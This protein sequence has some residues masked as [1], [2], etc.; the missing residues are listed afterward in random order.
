MIHRLLDIGDAVNW[1]D[2]LTRGLVSWWA[3]VPGS[4]RGNQW[5]DLCNRNH[6][7][8]T[9]GPTWQGPQGRVGGNGSLRLVS[10]GD[11]ANDFVR[12]NN[13][14]ASSPLNFTTALTL[15]VWVKTTDFDGPGSHAAI[16]SRWSGAA[17]YIFWAHGTDIKYG[18]D[19]TSGALVWSGGATQ[20]Q[21]GA[22]H[23]LALTH[24]SGVGTIFADGVSV[25][26][27]SVSQ[28][29]SL[30]GTNYDFLI[31][32]YAGAG[33]P[34]ITNGSYDGLI[35]DVGAWSR[36][37]SASEILAVYNDS[38]LG[39]PRMLN[40]QRRRI[41]TMGTGGGAYSVDA[42]AG[43]LVLSGSAAS[44]FHNKSLSA[45][46]GSFVLT[47]S[48]AS[49]LFG[50]S[51]SAGVGNLE[52]VGSD[53][54]IL[55]NSVID[56]QPGL[57]QLN[58]SSATITHEY[59]LS[60][61]VGVLQLSGSDAT[62]V[63]EYHLAADAGSLVLTGSDASIF[64]N[65]LLSVDAGTAQLSGSSAT[66]SVGY[67]LSADAGS[68]VLTG[69]DAT[70]DYNAAGNYNVSALAGSLIL[71]GSNASVLHN[72][73]LSADSDNLNLIG[74][75]ANILYNRF[76]STDAGSINTIGSSA[77]I[78]HGKL[79]SA[80]SGNVQLSGGAASILA[81]KLLN[82]S[83]GNLQF[84]GSSANISYGKLLLA[85]AGLVAL[86]GS[87]ANIT[88][89]RII[90]A[91]RG[92]IVFNGAS[93]TISSSGQNAYAE[94]V[95]STQ[96]AFLEGFW[97]L[98]ES[99]GATTAVDSSSNGNDSVSLLGNTFGI[100]TNLGAGSNTGSDFPG[101]SG[102]FIQLENNSSGGPL[103]LAEWTVTAW[104]K[105]DS[106]FGDTTT[107]GTGGIVAIPIVSK[108]RSE[109]DTP[110]LN[111]NYFLGLTAAGKLCG[112]F[113]STS[114]TNHPIT[115]GT[116]I[117]TDRWYFGALT[118]DGA[119]LKLYL[120]GSSDASPIATTDT[121]DSNTAQPACIGSAMNSSA[122]ANGGF[123]GIIDEVAIWGTAL[124]GSEINSLWEQGR[125]TVPILADIDSIST[126]SINIS[127]QRGLE[128]IES[129]IL[130]TI[131]NKVF[132]L[133]STRNK[134]FNVKK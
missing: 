54:T 16:I 129:F 29:S 9:N 84:S 77:S 111:L 127:V 63:H 24:A 51:L 73:F 50:Y 81:A 69:S 83:A 18:T 110:G 5:R 65:S 68:I 102:G 10:T 126:V 37:L 117:V 71:T 101:N 52:F 76:L 118:Y 80:N 12:D 130:S 61:D 104:F 75:D 106:D 43:S 59:H 4:P 34:P 23:H 49:I 53:A 64:K 109:A 21:D 133:G 35:D 72:R 93:A 45:S 47:G 22:W 89:S 120:N 103:G 17:G 121:P 94:L 85:E 105:P 6:G 11:S 55:K 92:Q 13:E 25:A 98:N 132:N 122:T 125:I 119:N 38:L 28:P 108:G 31:G 7:T 66:I 74:S 99:L 87:T 97:R 48:D 114:G 30:S 67:L 113:E 95:L 2:P 134:S 32:T 90:S 124:S 46:E 107:T 1:K 14:L 131:R 88:R 15:S 58:G 86:N 128:D 39:H 36:A 62:I 78:L 19:A 8:L 20:L 57:V 82:A 40:W 116:T 100:S 44:I 26:S 33:A 123:D 96:A 70:I 79:L 42:Q 56:A 91:L 41:F 115:G 112:D 60:V 27:G 3:S